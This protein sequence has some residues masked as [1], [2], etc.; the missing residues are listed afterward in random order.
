MRWT[1]EQI[2]T[3][4]VDEVDARFREENEEYRELV[5]Q[6]YVKFFE[7]HGQEAGLSMIAECMGFE[8]D[9]D[10]DSP[11]WEVYQA[12]TIVCESNVVRVET[13]G[14]ATFAEFLASLGYTSVAWSPPYVEPIVT[15]EGELRI[16]IEIYLVADWAD[17]DAHEWQRRKN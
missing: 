12:A 8:D 16:A 5:R 9:R 11:L 15:T 6:E 10:R 4:W 13:K 7:E 17:K 2:Y 3:Q 14:G 1:P